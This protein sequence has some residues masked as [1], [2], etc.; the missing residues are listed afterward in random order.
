M[1]KR[2]LCLFMLVFLLAASA[3]S[4]GEETPTGVLPYWVDASQASSLWI[5][6]PF[7]RQ[8][9]PPPEVPAASRFLIVRL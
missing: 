5:E 7:P 4:A 2:I 3:T 8:E 6:T 9:E 1:Q